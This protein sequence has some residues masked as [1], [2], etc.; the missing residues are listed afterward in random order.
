MGFG[1]AEPHDCFFP[2]TYYM[3]ICLQWNSIGRFLIQ[4]VSM[5]NGRLHMKDVQMH[6][7]AIA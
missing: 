3:R 1:E 7:A 2:L 6:A 4:I 5:L